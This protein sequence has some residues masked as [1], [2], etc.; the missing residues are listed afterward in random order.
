MK[1]CCTKKFNVNKHPNGEEIRSFE[2]AHQAETQSQTED[3][4]HGSCN[5]L[6]A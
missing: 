6:Q 5:I 2:A 3:A 4:T 1:F